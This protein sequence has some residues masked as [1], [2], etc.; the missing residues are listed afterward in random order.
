MG[1]DGLLYCAGGESDSYIFTYDP[2]SGTFD[3]KGSLGGC[4]AVL[5]MRC[6]NEGIIYIG[7]AVN[8]YFVKYDP[9]VSW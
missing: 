7:C 3:Q 5:R 2:V 4:G 8:G 1:K 9:D 6:A